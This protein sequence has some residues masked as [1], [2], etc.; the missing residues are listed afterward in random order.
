MPG[1]LTSV[2]VRSSL[3][4][5]ASCRVETRVMDLP[6]TDCPGEEVCYHKLLAWLHPEGLACPRRGRP[7]RPGTA[8][9][10]GSRS[11]RIGAAT[12]AGCSMPGP[13]RSSRK[14]VAAHDS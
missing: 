8:A 14:P 6:L 5:E 7:D 10:D 11:R 2:T 9:D 12:A 4:S 13:G 1:L 3:E